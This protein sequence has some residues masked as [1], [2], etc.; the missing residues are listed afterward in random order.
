MRKA[1]EL[2]IN[3]KIV[4][5]GIK[6]TSAETGYGYIEFEDNVVKTS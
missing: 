3:G 2:A 6:P 4:T 1:K 5:F